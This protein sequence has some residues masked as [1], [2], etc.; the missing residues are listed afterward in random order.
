MQ[1]EEVTLLLFAV[2]NSLRV[3]AYIP[4]IHKA[5]TAPDGASA[6]SYLT[7]SLFMFANLS[8]IAYA[9]V[10]QSDW[11]MATCFAI[12]ALCCVAILAASYW[13]ARRYSILSAG[14]STLVRA[15]AQRVD[16]VAAGRERTVIAKTGA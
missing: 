9:I 15:S 8:T 14:Q 13:R 3:L 2:C 10:N 1:L 5:A 6:I 12:N 7:W 16:G 4:Q 11:W